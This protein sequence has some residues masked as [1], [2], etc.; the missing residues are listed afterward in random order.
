MGNL[1]A[2]TEQYFDEA[3]G[4]LT[5]LMQQRLSFHERDAQQAYEKWQQH[6]QKLN[7]D[8]VFDRIR[9]YLEPFK[10]LNGQQEALNRDVTAT[11]RELLRKIELDS[12]IQAKL[13]SELTNL[14]TV[15]VKATSKNRFQRFMDS[16]FGGVKPV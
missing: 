12:Q 3:T 5:D 4:R 14:N 2:R 15:L 1:A 16:L 6:F 11:Q 7:E 8:N 9:Q 13:L 10:T